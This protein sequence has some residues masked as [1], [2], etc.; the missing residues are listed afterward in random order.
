MEM[1][2]RC[3][4]EISRA[5][6]H[7]CGVRKGCRMSPILFDIYIN[8]IFEGMDGVEVPGLDEKIPGL[9]FADD[10]VILADS[11]ISLKNS[12]L[13]LNL[14]AEKWEMKINNKKCGVIPVDAAVE[15]QLFI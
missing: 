14:W 11:E 6:Q 13:K 15:S 9:L 8:D 4:N 5:F 7:C 2:V 1:V 3:G 12:F 10:A